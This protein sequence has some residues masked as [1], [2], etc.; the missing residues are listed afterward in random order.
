MY[1]WENNIH[2]ISIRNNNHQHKHALLEGDYWN[3]WDGCEGMHKEVGKLQGQKCLSPP[4]KPDHNKEQRPRRERSPSILFVSVGWHCMYTAGTHHMAFNTQCTT[5]KNNC[6][7]QCRTLTNIILQVLKKR[8][9]TGIRNQLSV[10]IVLYFLIRFYFIS[11]WLFVF[12]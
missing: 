1:Q 11:L 12:N 5:H 3:H 10:I 7:Q 8:L 4:K 6:Q 9:P 2:S